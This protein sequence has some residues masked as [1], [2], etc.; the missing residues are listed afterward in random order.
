M[1]FDVAEWFAYIML[2]GGVPDVDQFIR[3]MD[4]MAAGPAGP[5]VPPGGPP[6]PAGPPTG[7]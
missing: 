1:K 3:E 4:P 7:S 6:V 2:M 5:A